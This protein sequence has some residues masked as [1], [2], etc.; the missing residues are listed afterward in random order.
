LAYGLSRDAVFAETNA[1]TQRGIGLLLLSAVLA[2]AAAWYGGRRYIREPIRHL[3]AAAR[4]WQEGDYAAR[5]SLSHAS[6]EFRRLATAYEAMADA[7]A[8]R[9]DHQRLLIHELN[10]RVKNT[11]ATVQALASQTYKGEPRDSEGRAAFEGRLFALSKAHDILTRENWEGADLRSVLTE[12]VEPYSRSGP[13]RIT[14]EGSALRLD[15]RMTLSLAMAIHELATNAAKYGALSASTG[16]VV[17]R[18]EVRPGE[19]PHLTLQW[20]ESRGPAVSPPTHKGFG[21][22]LIER[23]LATELAG[24]VRVTYEP[25]GVVC[26]IDAPLPEAAGGKHQAR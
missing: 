15:P 24:D 19:L 22:R 1:A 18:W 5:V 8:R 2:M 3:L 12:V 23:S 9:D 13:A 10:H 14:L 25:S 16:R 11:L 21:T 6:P 26:V 7:L 17:I 20:R 4:R